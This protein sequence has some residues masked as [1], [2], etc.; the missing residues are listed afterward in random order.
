MRQLRSFRHV[1]RDVSGDRVHTTLLFKLSDLLL[2]ASLGVY[3][4]WREPT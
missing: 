3:R 4:H 1:S 2:E